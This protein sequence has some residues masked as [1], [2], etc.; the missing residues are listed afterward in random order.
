MLEMEM[1][2]LRL[3]RFSD[4]AIAQNHALVDARADAVVL[5]LAGGQGG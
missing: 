5:R 4:T 1:S 3:T 2:F